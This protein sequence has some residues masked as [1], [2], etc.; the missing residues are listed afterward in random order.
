MNPFLHRLGFSSGDRVA[1]IHAD[2]FGMCQATLQAID[3]L[4]CA[5]LVSS[6]GVMV[7]CP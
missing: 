4:F 2:D 3:D 7:P 1:I 5:G 6:A